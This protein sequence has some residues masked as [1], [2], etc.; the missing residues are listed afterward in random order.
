MIVTTTN[1]LEGRTVKDYLGIVT[2][3]AI[4]GANIVKDI[5]A[6]VRDIVGGATAV[7]GV[8]LDYEVLGKAGSMLMV[9]AAGSAV[10]ISQDS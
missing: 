2:G 6:G 10:L 8:D 7:I 4:I 5:L 9:S 1:T 3:E